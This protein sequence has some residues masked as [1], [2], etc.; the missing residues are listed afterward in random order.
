MFIEDQAPS[1]RGYL[2]LIDPDVSNAQAG[3]YGV[4]SNLL[5]S[6]CQLI[7]LVD[8]FEAST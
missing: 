5:R 4:A 8:P 7:R 3:D 2:I 1:M 6:H